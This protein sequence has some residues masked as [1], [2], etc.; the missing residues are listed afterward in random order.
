MGRCCNC[1]DGA[2]A[3]MHCPEILKPHNFELG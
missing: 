1:V 2:I 3:R